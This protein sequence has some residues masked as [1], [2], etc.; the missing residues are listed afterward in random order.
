MNQ[1]KRRL[2][3]SRTCV[4]M[5]CAILAIVAIALHRASLSGSASPLSPTSDKSR[6]INFG[7]LPVAFEPNLGQTD[8]QVKYLARGN[9]YTLFL[10]SSEAVL[11]LAGRS[12]SGQGQLQTPRA[13]GQLPPAA[14]TLRMRV[15]D[16]DA[17]WHL[18]S[19]GILPGV[20]NYYIGSDPKKWHTKIP[21]YARVEYR[22]VYPG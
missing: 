4:L 15:G 5:G 6:Q 3:L 13:S 10:T 19:S 17:Q 14:S 11:S 16:T 2:G 8:P 7:S 1:P 22:D 12:E 21:T 20:T 18:A 9:G